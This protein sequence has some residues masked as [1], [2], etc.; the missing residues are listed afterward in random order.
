MILRDSQSFGDHCLTASEGST[1]VDGQTITW[2]LGQLLPGQEATLAIRSRINADALSPGVLVS[3][4]QLLTG[5]Y[6]V[7]EARTQVLIGVE[8]LPRTGETSARATGWMVL[9][10]GVAIALGV[11]LACLWPA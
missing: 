2:I 10:S 7:G 8:T 11:G 4:A 5:G 3:T 6:Q 1:L 9:L